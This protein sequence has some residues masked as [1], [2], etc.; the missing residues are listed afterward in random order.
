[1]TKSHQINGLIISA[2]LSS[3]MTELKALMAFNGKPFL[4]SIIQ[5][6]TSVCGSIVVVTGHESEK[7]QKETQTFL[8]GQTHLVN[9]KII[10]RFNPDYQKGMFSSLQT[11]LQDLEKNA[12]V[13]Y[14]FVDQPTLPVKFYFDFISELDD[15]YDWLQP[16]YQAKN[17]HPILFSP[18]MKEHILASAPSTSLREL[19]SAEEIQKKYWP[20]KYPQVLQDFNSIEDMKV[21]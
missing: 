5:K 6:L 16:T 20:C 4:G 17:G 3:R 12:W 9:K 1:M 18:K 7:I 11:G 8:N 19:K 14:H 10:W 13:L 2:G 21:V 15:K